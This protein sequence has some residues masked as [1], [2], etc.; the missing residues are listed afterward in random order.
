MG[1]PLGDA[2]E[3]LNGALIEVARVAQDISDDASPNLDSGGFKVH[4]ENMIELR[5]ALSAWKDASNKWL[6]E[7]HKEEQGAM[8]LPLRRG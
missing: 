4:H 3:A 2:E 5:A 1:H 6:E 8:H 7:I